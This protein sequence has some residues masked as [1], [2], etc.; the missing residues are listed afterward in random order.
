MVLELPP[1]LVSFFTLGEG[2]M[3]PRDKLKMVIHSST[4]PFLI[5]RLTKQVIMEMYNIVI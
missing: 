4:G 3:L 2:S 1:L 5:V